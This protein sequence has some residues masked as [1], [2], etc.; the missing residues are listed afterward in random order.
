VRASDVAAA[1]GLEER[2]VEP[3]AEGRTAMGQKS[4]SKLAALVHQRMN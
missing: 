3:I 1:L 4:W 2:H